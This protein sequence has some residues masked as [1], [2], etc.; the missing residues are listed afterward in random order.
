MENQ[1]AI[2]IIGAILLG[3]VFLFINNKKTENYD[4][5]RLPYTGP[6]YLHPRLDN[7]LNQDMLNP[8]RH[9]TY[10][11]DKR[12]GIFKNCCRSCMKS[13]GNQEANTKLYY[14]KFRALQDKVTK[15]E[16]QLSYTQDVLANYKKKLAFRHRELTLEPTVAKY[17]GEYSLDPNSITGPG[18][19]IDFKGGPKY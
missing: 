14:N 17:I 4:E 9:E 11:Y 10:D 6:Q 7:A 8:Y 5:V 1:N 2:I 15:L 3:I 16:T 13:L 18:V 12:F 19:E